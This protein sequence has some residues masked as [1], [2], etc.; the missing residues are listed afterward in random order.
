MKA[1]LAQLNYHIGNFAENLARIEQELRSAEEAGADLLILSELALTGYPPQDML[2][3]SSFIEAS[4]QALQKLASRSHKVGILVGAP[5]LNPGSSGKKLFNSAYF[6]YGGEIQQV[7]HKSLL[8]TYDIFDE[9]R[10][11]EPNK[12]FSLLDFKGMKIAITICEDLWFDQ[13]VE[14]AFSN[15]RLYTDNPL[16]KL[17]MLKPDLI[18]NLAASPFSY[19]RQI[20]K[21]EIF[22]NNAKKYGL[23]ILYVNQVGAQTE[24]IFEGGSLAVNH[25]GEIVGALKLFEEDKLMLDLKELCS[26]NMEKISFRVPDQTELTHHALILGIRDYFKKLDFNKATLGL[27]GGI[28]SAVTLVLAA[29][30]LGP[31]NIHVLLLPSKYS[32]DHSISDARHLAENLGVGFDIVS[33]QE[34]FDTYLK[35]MDPIFED[36]PEDI[37]EENMQSRIRGNMLMA[38]SNKFGHILLNTSNKSEAAVGYG[39]LYG[40]MAGGLSVLGDVYKTDVYR[41]AKFI[42][43]EKEVIPINIIE[44]PPSAELKPDQLDTDSLP[45]YETLDRILFAYIEQQKSSGEI[46][47]AGSDEKITH[48]I[49]SM[50]NQYE[51]KRYQTP[52]ILRISSKAFGVGRRMPLVAKY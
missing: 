51:Y 14:N 12:D 3:Y 13:P 23:P 30:A 26:G 18:I 49:I 37:T 45:D 22:T 19:L 2:E 42:N 43:R 15:S 17:A 40:D 39:T 24:L 9:Y 29:E 47:R 38:Y 21:T 11:F 16:D 32:S 48:R 33:I 8:P 50:V 7:F 46:I 52:P 1:I 10:Y 28:D 31:R 44:K 20:V 25:K 41:L 35:S 6:L 5:T 34:A 36:L 27:S 4:E